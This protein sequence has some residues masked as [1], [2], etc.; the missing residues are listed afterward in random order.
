[1]S[2]LIIDKV[3]ARVVIFD[4]RGKLH[5]AALALLGLASGDDS[6]PGISHRKL[7]SIRPDEPTTPAGRFVASRD[8]DVNDRE[9]LWVNYDSAIALHQVVKGA[10]P[11]RRGQRLNSP[12]PDDNRISY[13]FINM[14]LK[15]YELLVSH[16]FANTSAIDYILPE[17]RT[18]QGVFSSYDVK[19]YRQ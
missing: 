16:R 10:P 14:P 6:A 4:A 15:F 2:F 8:R 9:M 18:A 13:G 5:G 12:S 11:E 19:T 7:I 1:M 17:T 3:H